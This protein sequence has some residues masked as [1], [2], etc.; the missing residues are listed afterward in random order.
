M[1]TLQEAIESFKEVIPSADFSLLAGAYKDIDAQ[2]LYMVDGTGGFA[3]PNKILLNRDLLFRCG[4]RHFCFVALHELAH[5][6]RFEKC[7]F[8]Y[9][10]EKLSSDDFDEFFNHIIKEE[11]FADRYA[12]FL[13]Q[14]MFGES[15]KHYQ[16]GLDQ[17]LIRIRYMSELKRSMFG[18]F[19]ETVEDY[20]KLGESMIVNE[21]RRIP[22]LF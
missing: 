8:E 1:K 18:H 4:V 19:G 3:S 22:A 14:K 10:I 21:R 12:T 15:G 16:Q 2:V 5:Y 17:P 7:G 13:Y 6:R 20:N 9:H 11:L